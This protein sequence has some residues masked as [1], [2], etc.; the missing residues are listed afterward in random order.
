MPGIDTAIS[1]AATTAALQTAN[2]AKAGL[3]A[4]LQPEKQGAAQS[5]SNINSI[6]SAANQAI[7]DAKSKG[8]SISDTAVSNIN[9]KAGEITSASE[10]NA[11][12]ITDIIAE[13]TKVIAEFTAKITELNQEKKSIEDKIKEKGGQVKEQ[14]ESA[15]PESGEVIQEY[16]DNEGNVVQVKQQTPSQQSNGGGAV[17]PEIAAL[18][19]QLE[20]INTQIG[21]ISGQMT[22]AVA[23][24]TADTAVIVTENA[25]MVAAGEA[26]INGIKSTADNELSAETAKLNQAS[27]KAAQGLRTE[28]S[29][30]TSSQATNISSSGAAT[31][32]AQAARAAASAAAMDDPNKSALE[33]V[34]GELE[35]LSGDF[36]MEKGVAKS[37]N[38]NHTTA[39]Q[40]QQQ[41]QNAISSAISGDFQQFSQQINQAF[42]T[43]MQEANNAKNIM[44]SGNTEEIPQGNDSGNNQMSN[45]EMNNVIGT[46]VN[47]LSSIFGNGQSA[48]FGGVGG[49]PASG[50]PVSDGIN[51]VGGILQNVLS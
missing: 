49:F 9:N 6:F 16:V 37:N 22:T 7:Q 32:A 3:N 11:G 2:A 46:G 10:E 14:A 44:P 51:L 12:K 42:T 34:A 35:K 13:S 28:I 23:E 1:T 15:P 21:D 38:E 43:A 27:Q 8:T 31:S 45:A 20:G 48:G 47:V 33:Q 50:N 36:G 40:Y 19:S 17:D 25:T 29:T 18:Q 30:Q 41:I 39:T 24:R 26:E 4:K 5:K